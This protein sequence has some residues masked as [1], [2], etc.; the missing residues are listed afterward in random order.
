MPASHDNG[1][2][3]Y[4]DSGQ[5]ASDPSW[6]GTQMPAAGNGNMQAVPT[7]SSVPGEYYPA[8]GH[9]QAGYY[10]GYPAAQQET[11]AYAQPAYPAAAYDQHGYGP[12]EAVYG[13]DGY[14]GHS[15]YGTGGY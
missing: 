11:V 10:P 2:P 15:G 13:L 5:Y 14:Q 6:Y 7:F 8:N 4:A 9:A 1:Y 12:Q 3:A